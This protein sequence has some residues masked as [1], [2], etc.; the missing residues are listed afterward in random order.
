MFHRGLEKKRERE[1]VLTPNLLIWKIMMRSNKVPILLKTTS[2]ELVCKISFW[3]SWSMLPVGL[4]VH[5]AIMWLNWA[6][7][8]QQS[9]EQWSLSDI[10]HWCLFIKTSQ[11][12]LLCSHMWNCS[13]CSIHQAAC[14]IMCVLHLCTLWNVSSSSPGFKTTVQGF[15][16]G[17]TS[18][19]AK[20]WCY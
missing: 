8:S 6:C 18:Q 19:L 5:S 11:P 12:P 17:G 14:Y 3:D 20:R 16:T 9:S 13:Q 7:T 10:F 2:S 1:R 15:L 4:W